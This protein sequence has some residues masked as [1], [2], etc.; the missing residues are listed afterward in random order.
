MDV[1]VEKGIGIGC[2][3]GTQN[4]SISNSNVNI[5]C[6][7]SN[8]SAIGST[9]TSGGNIEIEESEVSILANG[10]NLYLIGAKEGDL[11]LKFYESA[12]NLRG[13]GNNVLALGTKDLKSHIKSKH[14]ICNIKLASGTPVVFGATQEN[15]SFSGGL[16]SVS[17]N[18]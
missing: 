8:I 2:L 3:E 16:Q 1:K 13:E 5:L 17:V 7:G 10:Q 9:E 12:I 4:T 15:T 14:V 6:A 18:E 11:N